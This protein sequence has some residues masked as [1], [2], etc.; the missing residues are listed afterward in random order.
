VKVGIASVVVLG[1]A[2]SACATVPPAAGRTS[3]SSPREEI[4][5]LRSVREERLA[6]SE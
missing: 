5:V 4:L 3:P 6:Q 1:T 2:L